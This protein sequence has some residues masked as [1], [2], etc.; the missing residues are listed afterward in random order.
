MQRVQ[1]ICHS[2]NRFALLRSPAE[3]GRD[4]IIDYVGDLAHDF[5]RR[6]MHGVATFSVSLPMLRSRGSSLRTRL[7]R[8][9]PGTPGLPSD[10][11]FFVQL[12]RWFRSILQVLQIIRPETLVRWHRAGFRSY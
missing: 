10:R 9:D 4:V 8:G 6:G 7:P 3:R 12:Y 11:L 1:M 2:E 5:E